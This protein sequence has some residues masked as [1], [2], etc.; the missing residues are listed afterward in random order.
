MVNKICDWL[1][2]IFVFVPMMIVCF[3]NVLIVNVFSAHYITFFEAVGV[4]LII[5]AILWVYR[6]VKNFPNDTPGY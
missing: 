1:F 6:R 4:S 5:N 2:Y 3:W